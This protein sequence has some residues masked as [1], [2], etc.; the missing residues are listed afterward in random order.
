MFEN[1]ENMSIKHDLIPGF[2][3]K[4][5]IMALLH[6]SIILTR[7][8]R[9]LIQSVLAKTDAKLS[10]FFVEKKMFRYSQTQIKR[11]ER[12]QF[13]WILNDSHRHKMDS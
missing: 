10:Q 13:I 2:F 5:A 11:N 8:Q 12:M 6:R 3:F 9:I 7:Q 1:I 4:F